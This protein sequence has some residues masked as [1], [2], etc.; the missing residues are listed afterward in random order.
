MNSKYFFINK[1]INLATESEAKKQQVFEISEHIKNEM[2]SLGYQQATNEN[3]TIDLVFSIGG[4][5][6]MMH[7]MNQFID[8]NSLI[9]GINAGNVGFLTPYSIENVFD[10]KLINDVKDYENNARIEKRSIL[11]YRLENKKVAAV[12]EYAFTAE[13]PNNMISFSLEIETNGHCSRAGY[14]KANTL[15]ISGPVGSTAY[16]MNAGGAIIDPSMKAMQ[17]FMIAPTTLGIRPL[18]IGVNSKIRLRFNE[19]VKI[20]T[21]GF[22]TDIAKPNEPVIVSLIEK[23]ISLLVPENWNFYSVLSKK[24]H[25]NNGLDV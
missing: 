24:L 5:G 4:D 25:W 15:L 9:I 12:N 17:I 19:N 7:S 14:Y 8:K 1:K 23:E 20:F 13:Q 16:N 11:N 21:D 22:E 3:E 10:G 18:I 6:T 2:I